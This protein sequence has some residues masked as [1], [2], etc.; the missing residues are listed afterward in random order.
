MTHRLRAGTRHLATACSLTAAAAAVDVAHTV[1]GSTSLVLAGVLTMAAVLL[2]RLHE[3]TV[4]VDEDEVVV[5][6]LLSTR[7]LDRAEVAAV[8]PGQWRSTLLLTDGTEV[9][10][11]LREEDLS[12][13]FELPVTVIDLRQLEHSA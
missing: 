5:S 1:G 11:L 12:G 3:V 13:D 8:V 6:N 7:T 2:M 4:T 10:T 9:P